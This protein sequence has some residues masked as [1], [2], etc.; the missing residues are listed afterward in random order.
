MTCSLLLKL[1]QGKVTTLPMTL[2]SLSSLQE[3]SFLPITVVFGFEVIY[4]FGRVSEK[5][6]I[7]LTCHNTATASLGLSQCE[8]QQ[9]TPRVCSVFHFFVHGAKAIIVGVKVNL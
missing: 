7:Q 3:V 4:P 9:R 8:L 6:T 1:C 5:F 2:A